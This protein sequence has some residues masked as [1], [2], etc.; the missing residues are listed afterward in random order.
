MCWAESL[1][2]TRIPPVTSRRRPNVSQWRGKNRLAHSRTEH[3]PRAIANLPGLG[4]QIATT[5]RPLIPGT[6]AAFALGAVRCAV[7]LYPLLG[8][9]ALGRPGNA[10]GGAVRSE[11]AYRLGARA[12]F[13]MASNRDVVGPRMGTRALCV[14]MP[15][16]REPRQGTEVKASIPVDGQ[17]PPTHSF[18]PASPA[19]LAQNHV[20]V[21]PW[22]SG[23]HSWQQIAKRGP[24]AARGARREHLWH[25]AAMD[26]GRGGAAR[27]PLGVSTAAII[28]ALGQGGCLGG[29]ADGNEPFDGSVEDLGFVPG[30][31]D[32]L[33]GQ[34]YGVVVDGHDTDEGT[35]TLEV[36]CVCP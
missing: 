18:R 21:L 5:Q 33:A 12:A 32:A 26:Q 29:G 8:I 25:T 19:S 3:S 14:Q 10:D 28:A 17:A 27:R 34:M 6:L 31:F 4:A 13:L 2:P 20:T 35:Y 11:A 24:R 9:L 36:N 30:K 15:Q 7:A 22:L 23:R 16:S 1:K